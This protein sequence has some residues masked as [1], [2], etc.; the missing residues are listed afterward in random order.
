MA[1]N[2]EITTEAISQGMTRGEANSAVENVNVL[3]QI[4]APSLMVRLFQY[5]P[6]Y[7]F[8]F[9]AI[10]C[11]VSSMDDIY[12]RCV[13]ASLYFDK[14]DGRVKNLKYFIYDG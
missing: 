2:A 7:P 10:S 4:I 8:R 9:G 3:L 13:Y 11:I 6:T 12:Y 5:N 14:K 1:V